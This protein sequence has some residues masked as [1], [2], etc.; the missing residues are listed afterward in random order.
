VVREL[1]LN[2]YFVNGVAHHRYTGWF[3][4]HSKEDLYMEYN[5]LYLVE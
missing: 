2:Q 5:G 4:I 1:D 3:T